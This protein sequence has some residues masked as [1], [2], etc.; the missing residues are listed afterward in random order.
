MKRKQFFFEK[1]NQ[2]TF[3]FLVLA[4][5]GCSSPNP[6]YYALQVVPG[7]P[8]PGPAASIEVRRP[9]LAGYLDRNDIV[10]KSQSYRISLNSQ[11]QW[12]EPLGDMIG[13]VFTQDLSQ[14]L[15]GRSVF[16][17]S[18][19]ITTNADMRVEIDVLNFDE[20][21]SGNVVLNAEVAVEQGAT[22]RPLASHHVALSIAPSG[23]DPSALAA[24]MSTLL[25]QL[26]DQ[27]AADTTPK[28]G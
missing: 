27:V 8:Q 14:R 10:L 11:Q 20:D 26:A 7:T 25:A 21:G 6:T 16:S 12:A 3:A 28:S 19:A 2:K 18:G 24:A 15:P 23:P 4:L 22:H 9:G 1:K 13:R 5:S 17:Q